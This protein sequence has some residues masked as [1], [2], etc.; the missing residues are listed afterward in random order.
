MSDIT[1]MVLEF[2]DVAI[3]CPGGNQAAINLAAVRGEFVAMECPDKESVHTVLDV[4]EGLVSPVEGRVSFLGKYWYSLDDTEGNKM[5]GMV[6][7]VLYG[8]AWI[9]NLTII[10]NISLALS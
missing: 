10:E 5:R 6:G 2:H 7:R 4:S 3:R 9:S 8:R 1:N